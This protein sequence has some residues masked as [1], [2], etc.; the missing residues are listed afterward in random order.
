MAHYLGLIS[1]PNNLD[2]ISSGSRAGGY[3]A[4]LQ[5]CRHPV[6]RADRRRA[7]TPI[8]RCILGRAGSTLKR[9]SNVSAVSWAVSATAVGRQGPSACTRG[10]SRAS[11]QTP[12][13]TRTE[14]GDSDS[15]ASGFLP[16]YFLC[17]HFQENHRRHVAGNR[18]SCDP[19]RNAFEMQ[20]VSTTE[21]AHGA[22][23]RF[24]RQGSTE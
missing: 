12:C 9:F 18:Q 20:T 7:G 21:P 5:R 2:R 4:R 19:R 24:I 16:I 22:P 17:I 14:S 6:G 1:H 23:K 13:K 8:T 10:R 15:R 11:L 3:T